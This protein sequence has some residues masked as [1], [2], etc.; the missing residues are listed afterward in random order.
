MARTDSVV[1]E[2]PQS[3]FPRIL[4]AILAGAVLFRIVA[5]V[6]A[7]H[8]SS[9]TGAGLVKWQPMEKVAAAAEQQGKF[10]LY[11]FTAAWCAPCHLLDEEGWGDDSIA[12]MVTQ[13]YVAARV[14]DREREEGKNPPLVEE[15]QRRYSVRAFPTL[16]AA[17]ASGREVARMEGYGGR[18]RLVQFLESTQKKP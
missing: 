16:I 11:D 5:G 14:V 18:E 6:T 15:L 1:R 9:E 12:A 10:L 3:S 17:D 8:G 13:R 4:L 2:G 7:S